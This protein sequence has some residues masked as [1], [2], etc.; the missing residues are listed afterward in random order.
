M[1]TLDELIYYCNTKEP[2][3]AMF[4]LGD[5]GCGKTHLVEKDLQEA[6]RDTHV[7]VRVS[8]FGISSF[9]TLHD[10]V[11]EKWFSALVPVFSKDGRSAEEMAIGKNFMKAVNTVLKTVFPKAGYLVDAAS[12]ILNDVVVLPVVEDIHSKTTKR[13]V[14]VFDDADCTLLNP[15]ELLGTINDYCENRDFHTIVIGN[16]ENFAEVQKD[17]AALFRTAKE[18][19]VA[20]MVSF[21]PDF[22]K[23][24]H[25]LIEGKQWE[26][27]AYAAFLKKH[28]ATIVDVIGLSGEE[29]EEQA[30][31]QGKAGGNGPSLGRCHNL[32][33]LTTA[34][35]VF[36][37]IYLKMTEAGISDLEPYLRCFLAFYLAERG[38]VVRDGITSYRF[39]EEELE[40][41]YPGFSSGKLFDSVRGWIREGYWNEKKFAEELARAKAAGEAK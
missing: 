12:N 27:P 32:R 1:E 3:G 20:Y 10:V 24:V 34:L 29:A 14:L 33:S 18:K 39:T 28:E 6:L 9:K 40:A 36:H 26:S 5:S 19:T 37:R 31:D 21:H 13:V 23:I 25:G 35:E 17:N 8:L 16:R 30:K 4:L 22:R 38:G 2:A 41:I 11:K 7:I 15:M